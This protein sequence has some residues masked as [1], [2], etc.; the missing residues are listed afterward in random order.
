VGA[1]EKRQRLLITSLRGKL[2]RFVRLLAPRLIDRIAYRAIR[3]G[4]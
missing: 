3:R 2:G 1:M 4:V